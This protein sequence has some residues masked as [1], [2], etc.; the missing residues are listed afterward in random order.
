VVP[1]KEISIRLRGLIECL[2]PTKELAKNRNAKILK[3]AFQHNSMKMLLVQE[4]GT[5]F[6]RV[7][8]QF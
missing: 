5:T 1:D 2:F 7:N 8:H 3:I 6:L 4:I